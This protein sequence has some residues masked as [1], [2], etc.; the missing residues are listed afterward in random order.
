MVEKS[1]RKQ[2]REPHSEIS[3]ILVYFGL[4]FVSFTFVIGAVTFVSQYQEVRGRYYGDTGYQ[5]YITIYLLAA[6]LY[7]VAIT[8]L[9]LQRELGYY[10]GLFMI[11]LNVLFSFITISASALTGTLGLIIAAVSIAIL[12]VSKKYLKPFSEKDATVILILMALIPVWVAA[13]W[14]GNSQPQPEELQKIVTK[15]AIEKNDVKIC[16]KLVIGKDFCTMDF[17]RDKRNYSLCESLSSE[18][19]QD[20]CYL[21]IANDLKDSTVCKLIKNEYNRGMCGGNK[22]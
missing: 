16:D 8:G 19:D 15:E 17:A 2:K 18:Q 21:Y 3:K 10:L 14:W 20:L 6:L 22:S 5:A 7:F 4:L 13:N 12:L 11:L 9:L 1:N